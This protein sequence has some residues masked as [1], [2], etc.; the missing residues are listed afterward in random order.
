MWSLCEPDPYVNITPVITSQLYSTDVLEAASHQDPYLK[1][2]RQEH[3]N[4]SIL[5]ESES[6]IFQYSRLPLPRL[7]S[8]D[9]RDILGR[10]WLSDDVMDLAQE[11]LQRRFPQT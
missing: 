9:R 2:G 1:D 11:I 4:S 6:C 7:R 8:S 3:M 10:A 5:E